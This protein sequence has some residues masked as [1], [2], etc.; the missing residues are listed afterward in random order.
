MRVVQKVFLVNYALI[1]SGSP[2]DMQKL[3]NHCK[4]SPEFW[5]LSH[6]FDEFLLKYGHL[7]AIWQFFGFLP[8]P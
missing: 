6:I 8:Y 2:K 7:M 1:H 3:S 5:H 4:K